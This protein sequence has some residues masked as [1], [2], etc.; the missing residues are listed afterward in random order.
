MLQLSEVLVKDQWGNPGSNII[1]RDNKA[2]FIT[3]EG[4]MT[5]SIKNK[6]VTINNVR[7]RLDS[8]LVTVL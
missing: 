8:H 2:T 3:N 5:R 7:Y 6:A 1:V 4:A